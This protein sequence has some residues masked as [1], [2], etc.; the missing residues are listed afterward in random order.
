MMPSLSCGTVITVV[1][2]D[3]GTN[4]I[5]APIVDH[6]PNLPLLDCPTDEY[7]CAVNFSPRIIDLTRQAFLDL[8]GQ[9]TWGILGVKIIIP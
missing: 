5:T 3:C 6:G 8:G 7:H 2:I 4:Q 9:L 1:N